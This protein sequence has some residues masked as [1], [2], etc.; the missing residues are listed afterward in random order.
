MTNTH[1]RYLPKRLFPG[2]PQGR[3]N[4]ANRHVVSREGTDR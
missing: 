2:L 4:L 1:A 3:S